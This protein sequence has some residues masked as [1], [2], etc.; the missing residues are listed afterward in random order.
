MNTL[1]KRKE[2]RPRSERI[3]ELGN[4][5]YEI[6]YIIYKIIYTYI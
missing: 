5:V 1:S 4:T 2:K 6:I 3:K